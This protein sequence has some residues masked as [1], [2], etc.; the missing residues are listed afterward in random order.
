MKEEWSARTLGN[1]R[2]VRDR[3]MRTRIAS[4][5]ADATLPD[6][7]IFA[8]NQA[9]LDLTGYSRPEVIGRNCRFL[10]R[11]GKSRLETR[12]FRRAIR[13][14]RPAV[15]EIENYRKCGQP[16]LNGVTIAPIFDERGK[17]IAYLGTQTDI[18][19][20]LAQ[21]ATRVN[22]EPQLTLDKLTP[23]QKEA[24]VLL[25]RGVP[26]KKIAHRLEISERAVKM[27]R[28]KAIKR[29]GVEST[30]DAIRLAVRAGF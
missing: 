30:A 1:V 7:P 12:T 25:A 2:Q 15:V 24:I 26:V 13:D 11:S 29:L 9:F 28:A 18:S 8:C 5:I 14:Q 22:L 19:R 23:R 17:L 4:V 16:F 21:S 6:F 10:S 27:H 3:M 20:G